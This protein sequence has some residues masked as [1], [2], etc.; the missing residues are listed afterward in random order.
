VGAGAFIAAD[1]DIPMLVMFRP[2]GCPTSY[3]PAARS[4]SRTP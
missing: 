4:R 3:P 1:P 2:A